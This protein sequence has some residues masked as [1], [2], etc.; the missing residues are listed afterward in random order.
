MKRLRRV[1]L[2]TKIGW[3]RSRRRVTCQERSANRRLA[4]APPAP[5]RTHDRRQADPAGARAWGDGG[6]GWAL[7]PPRGAQRMYVSVDL[8]EAPLQAHVLVSVE[9]D[10][11]GRVR[12]AGSAEIVVPAVDEF[13][14]GVPS[15]ALTC[16][17]EVYRDQLP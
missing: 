8:L 16:V 4:C 14:A 13:L 6:A 11:Y 17:Q 5:G 7:V 3:S 10:R 1:H 12:I 2:S 15:E 9:S